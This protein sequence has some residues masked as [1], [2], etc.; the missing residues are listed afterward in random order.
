MGESMDEWNVEFANDAGCLSAV[1]KKYLSP[2]RKKFRQF[3]QKEVLREDPVR[4]PI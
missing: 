4:A 3:V 2:W 1:E